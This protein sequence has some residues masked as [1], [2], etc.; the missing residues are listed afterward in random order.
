MFTVQHISDRVVMKGKN[1]TGV[2]GNTGSI[3]GANNLL[4]HLAGSMYSYFL[5][6]S[7]KF[8][9]PSLQFYKAQQ[10]TQFHTFQF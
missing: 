8:N 9:G 4:Y 1:T 7:I 10:V 3:D 2:T 6:G 5:A